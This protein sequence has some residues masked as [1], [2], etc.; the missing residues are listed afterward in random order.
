VRWGLLNL[1][2]DDLKHPVEVLHHFMVPEADHAISVSREFLGPRR[3]GS[4]PLHVLPTIE[5]DHELTRRA[6]EIDN[7][8]TDRVLATKLQTWQRPKHPP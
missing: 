1:A 3:V 6:R 7:E 4:D 2:H 8:S 5:L